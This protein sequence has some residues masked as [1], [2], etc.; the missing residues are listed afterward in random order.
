[1]RSRFENSA[2]LEE[3]QRY[4]KELF[5][6]LRQR[7][8]QSIEDYIR[9]TRRLARGMS[10]ENQHLVASQFVK[11]L[12][13]RGLRVQTMSGLSSRPT[14]N[15]AITKVQRIADI[16]DIDAYTG[17]PEPSSDED[18][19]GDDK[20]ERLYSGY[21]DRRRQNEERALKQKRKKKEQKAEK[22]IS[23]ETERI[24]KN[25]EELKEMLTQKQ[26]KEEISSIGDRQLNEKLP[27]VEAYVVGNRL[28]P[29]VPYP[30]Q[31]TYI[32]P[33]MNYGP[34]QFH[35]VGG[36]WSGQL[37]DETVNY[38]GNQG[39]ADRQQWPTYEQSGLSYGQRGYTNIPQQGVGP[40]SFSSTLPRQTALQNRQRGRSQLVCYQ[41]GVVGNVRYE[42]HMLPRPSNAYNNS[43][44]YTGQ[45]FGNAPRNGF[46]GG[47]QD[48]QSMAI[49]N[50]RS[51]NHF[52]APPIAMQ[53]NPS[54]QMAN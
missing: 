31:P 27:A 20:E 52:P 39:P 43:G 5:L 46:L 36:A 38:T 42:C 34:P 37:R 4:A 11:G 8:G 1:M 6:S 9:L 2:E 30:S 40:P 50:Q 16:I 13:S 47:G 26:R 54:V 21:W 19:S 7:R 51:D 12:D 35:S 3:E 49:P 41:C 22:R 32:Q 17:L 48:R 53:Q 18:E 45:S 23:E 44:A 14:V 24:R 33:N 29:P 15:E 28:A 25:L 10:A